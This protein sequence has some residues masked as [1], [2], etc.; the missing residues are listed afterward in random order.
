MPPRSVSSKSRSTKD[1]I[2]PSCTWPVAVVYSRLFHR[3][4]CKIFH[5]S[6]FFSRKIQTISNSSSMVLYNYNHNSKIFHNIKPFQTNSG[7]SHPPGEHVSS[8]WRPTGWPRWQ[9]RP[10][11]KRTRECSARLRTT[12]CRSP[13]G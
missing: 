11:A 10:T 3:L 7:T 13:D 12:R 8:L 6:M 2:W 5:R 4:F 9:R 1:L